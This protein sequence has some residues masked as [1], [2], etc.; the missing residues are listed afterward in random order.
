MDYS[1]TLSNNAIL[2]IVII[3]IIIIGII[4][5]IAIFNDN[6]NNNNNNNNNGGGAVSKIK[7]DENITN[8]ETK[9][10]LDLIIS[11]QDKQLEIISG[12]LSS[13]NDIST[14][15][16]STNDV[17]TSDNNDDNNDNFNKNEEIHYNRNV[18]KNEEVYYHEDESLNT[19][20][21]EKLEISSEHMKNDINP[22]SIDF[23][24]E[25]FS[26]T[27]E[28][29]EGQS[30]EE[31]S[32]IKKDIDLSEFNINTNQKLA[33][34]DRSPERKIHIPFPKSAKIDHILNSD[35]SSPDEDTITRVNRK[36]PLP[37]AHQKK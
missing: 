26:D 6:N 23:Q 32:I 30:A 27:T 36:I 19:S 11:N 5:L 8:N 1:S 12:I 31:P 3:V 34:K 21:M 24:H 35:L 20:E 15:N 9:E 17:I 33:V 18:V 10:K 4:I 2:I 29:F 7:I 14:N 13:V 25:S 37:K 16:V 28:F 22:P